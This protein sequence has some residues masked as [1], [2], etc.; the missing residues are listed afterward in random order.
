MKLS[1]TPHSRMATA[2]PTPLELLRRVTPPQAVI[3][4]GA[5]SGHGDMH[6]WR[7]WQTPY[8]LIIDADDARLAWARQLATENPAWQIRS[9]VLAENNGEANYYSATNSKEDGLIEPDALSALWPNLRTIAQTRRQTV[10]LDTLLSEDSLAVVHQAT[11]IWAIIECLPALPI[12]KGAGNAIERWSVIWLRVLLNPLGSIDTGATLH[13]VEAYLQPLGYSCIQVAEGNHPG[14]GQALFMRDW[15]TVLAQRD[16]LQNE[17]LARANQL[18]EEK[19]ALSAR[20]DALQNEVAALAHARDEQAQLATERMAS[21]DALTHERD[22]LAQQ[23]IERQT[24]LD[25]LTQTH[26]ALTQANSALAARQDALQSEVTAITQ[27]RDEQAQFASE[28]LASIDALTHERD[29]LAQQAAERQ[30]QLDALNQTHTALAEEKSAL[31][32]KQDAL[33]S[34]V[35]AITH[36]RDDQ[37]QLANERK[38]ELDR[39]QSLLK[40]KEARIARLDS[41]I[42]ERDA[43]QHQLN[44][45]MIKAEA[46]IDLIKDVLL[47]EPGL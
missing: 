9:T 44:E 31:A 41:E 35:T 40:Q 12:L 28:R 42:I 32:A 17:I 6:L 34:E 45:E 8:V 11:A 21:I 14:I 30:T 3:H 18:A 46:Q 22:T 25:A 24:Q 23:A 19:S 39:T 38:A 37:A 20:Q 15:H 10:R 36:A 5:G 2:S 16:A 27:A 4:I 43:R 47:R 33:Q 26:T 13:A 7:Q 1:S 29:T